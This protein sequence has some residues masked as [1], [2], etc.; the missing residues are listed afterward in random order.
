[1][2]E[3]QYY[4]FLAV[5]RPLD[6]AAQEKLRAVS[7][8]ARISA[9]SFVN[10]YDFGSLKADPID[11]LARHF[12]VF[13]Y[14][15]NWGTRRVAIRLPREH[16]DAEAIARLD[17]G[18]LASVRIRDKHVILDIE[19]SDEE[20][21]WDSHDD[22]SGWMAS[23]APLRAHLL[24]GGLHSLRHLLWV[25]EVAAGTVDGD[26]VEPMPCPGPLPP[27]LRSL[28]GFLEA[29]EDVLAAAHGSSAPPAAPAEPDL[30]AVRAVIAGMPD[31]D[32]VTYLLRLYQG[33]D[34]HLRLE[35]RKR[36]RQPF[37]SAPDLPPARLR[38]AEEL[39][40]LADAAEDARLRAEQEQAALERRRREAEEAA[41]R[42]RRVKALAQRGESAWREVEEQIALRNA[43]GYER[44]TALLADL[45]ELAA[46]THDS[47]AFARRL[48]TVS[49]HH[50]QKRG[51]I[52]RLTKAGLL[53]V[54]GQTLWG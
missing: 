37:A 9:S 20:P 42:A 30:D 22:G 5:D 6:A 35:L 14:L 12:D 8:R 15:A 28:A 43:S 7:S 31:T 24:D 44:A 34:P 54:A 32:K 48:A 10:S 18:G 4:E 26:A 2:S 46:T 51:F 50:S 38:T 47:D 36:C 25:L 3:Y 49:A 19:R 11:L 13:V 21:E 45:R 17:T 40:Q 16:V 33:D 1:M 23:L 52:N 39:M 29:D 53:P 41:A 27:P